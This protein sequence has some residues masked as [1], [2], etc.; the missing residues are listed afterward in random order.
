MPIDL[1]K[2]MLQV[3]GSASASASANGSAAAAI[4]QAAEL[5]ADPAPELTSEPSPKLGAA[6]VGL[7]LD[8]GTGA[9]AEPEPA[10]EVDDS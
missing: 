10:R 5:R 7:E 3:L 1:M 8:T 9:P 6:I 2:P 4:G